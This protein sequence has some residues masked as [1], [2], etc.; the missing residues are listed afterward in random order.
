VPDYYNRFEIHKMVHILPNEEKKCGTVTTESWLSKW[1]KQ[2]NRCYVFLSSVAL[3]KTLCFSKRYRRN[4][5]NR[6]I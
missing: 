2:R 3:C 5:Q 6:Y 1:M 4:L